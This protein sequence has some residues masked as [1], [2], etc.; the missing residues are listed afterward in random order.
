MNEN[1][2]DITTKIQEKLGAEESAKISDDI[3]NILIFEETNKKVLKE[4]D[5]DITKLK[6]DKDKLIQANGNLMLKIPRGKEEDDSF[7]DSESDKNETK[8][9]FDFRTLF[10]ENGKLRK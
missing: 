10:D 3:A 1:L 9:P 6:N 8:K 5:D 4:K 2:T 7:K